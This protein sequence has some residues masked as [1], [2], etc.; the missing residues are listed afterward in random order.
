MAVVCGKVGARLNGRRNRC[1]A[2]CL[3][4]T[5]EILDIVCPTLSADSERWVAN[6]ATTRQASVCGQYEWRQACVISFV[7]GLLMAMLF[8][9]H[10][11]LINCLLSGGLPSLFL[12]SNSPIR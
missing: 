9:V 5:L 11:L 8:A 7:Y 10:D 4:L 12:G 1:L 6:R 2:K 3:E